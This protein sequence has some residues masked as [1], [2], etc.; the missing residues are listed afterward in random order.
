MLLL[1]YNLHHLGSS[2]SWLM[3]GPSE[4]SNLPTGCLSKQCK[5]NNNNNKI[6]LIKKQKDNDNYNITTIA[7]LL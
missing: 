1:S 5:I 7:L 6:K 2:H 3:W 4:G